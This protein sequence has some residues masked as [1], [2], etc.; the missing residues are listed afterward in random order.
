MLL[1]LFLKYAD[2]IAPLIPIIAFLFNRKQVPK[3]MYIILGYLFISALL[4]GYSNYLADRYINNMYLYHII[5]IIEF[6][7]VSIFILSILKSTGLKKIIYAQS[8]FFVGFFFFNLAFLEKIST[9]SS[10]SISL[11]FLLLIIACS[12]YYYE[13]TNSETILVYNKDGDF[14]VVSGFLF[15]FCGSFL[16]FAFYKYVAKTNVAFMVNFW[17]V[18]V[19]LYVIRCLI[20]S[21]GILCYR[22]KCFKGK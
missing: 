10:N 2:S 19:I 20:I 22:K 9:L 7:C 13:L 11:E 15:H 6:T 8:G 18:Q 17:N 4:Y 21:I 14:W 1:S 5:C 16:T 3:R 12:F